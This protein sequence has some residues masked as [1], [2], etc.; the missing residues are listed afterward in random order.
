M[1]I[2]RDLLSLI[3]W[4]ISFLSA[5]SAVVG[6]L[7]AGGREPVAGLGIFFGFLLVASGASVLNHM[8]DRVTDAVMER[9][10]TRPLPSGRIQVHSAG[11]LAVLCLGL[12]VT[13]L[14]EGFPLRVPA[15]AVAAVLSYNGL[16]A[17]LRRKTWAAVFLGAL[18]G[19][20]PV[21]GGWAS[22]SGSLWDARFLALAGISYAW[23]VPHFWLLVLRF[24]REY[25]AAGLPTPRRHFTA[26]QMGRIAFS[27]IFAFG[28]LSLSLPLFELLGVGMPAVLLG[29]MSVCMVVKSVPLLREEGLEKA[30]TSAFSYVNGYALS[31]L[32]LL[33]ASVLLTPGGV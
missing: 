4:R 13:F 25:E 3:K 31:V 5:L 17:W 15:F 2:S 9:T 14:L 24:G 32:T 27:W 6:M 12:G 7:A 20:F 11:G 21:A 22:V 10:R 23:Q 18:S 29:G 28:A 26:N 1:G 8:Q 33:G 19:V 16:Y 30:A